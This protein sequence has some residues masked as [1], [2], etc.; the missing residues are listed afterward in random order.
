M[1]LENLVS[2]VNVFVRSVLLS[3]RK[4]VCALGEEVLS[5]MLCVYTQKR[6]SSTLKEELVTFFQ[7]QLCVHHPK[8]AKTLETGN[9]TVPDEP[10]LHVTTSHEK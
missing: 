5:A 6:P 2:A 10:P 8:G 9:A 7:L 3:C 1:V 4:R